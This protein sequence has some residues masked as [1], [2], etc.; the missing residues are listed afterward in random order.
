V[1][2]TATP[3][4][5]Q[6]FLQLGFLLAAFATVLL[7]DRIGAQVLRIDTGPNARQIHGI[8]VLAGRIAAGWALGLAFRIQLGVGSGAEPD[9]LLRRLVAVPA[10]LLAAWPILHVR[11]PA[12]VTR[13]LPAWSTTGGAF[14][15]APVAAITLGLVVALG[16][17]PGRRR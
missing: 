4:R 14:D 6:R 16:V 5:R 7:V 8:V 15:L 1:S 17:V 10:S 3:T 13:Q 12:G 2:R 9:R 11:L